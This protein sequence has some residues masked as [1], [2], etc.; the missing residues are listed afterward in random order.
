[1]MLELVVDNEKQDRGTSTMSEEK[2]SSRWYMAVEKAFKACTVP[3]GY[4]K[5]RFILCGSEDENAIIKLTNDGG[6][7]WR[8]FKMPVE[9]ETD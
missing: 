2:K 7:T 3:D 5:N 8:K 4:S 6:K 9:L 1:M